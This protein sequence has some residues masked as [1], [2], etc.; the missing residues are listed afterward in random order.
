MYNC[1][2]C[3]GTIESDKKFTIPDGYTLFYLHE[4]CTDEIKRDKNR[5]R[6]EDTIKD[7]SKD[8]DKICI[9]TL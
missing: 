1:L 2:W 6:S 9:V 4:S 5:I 8:E 3:N 7:N